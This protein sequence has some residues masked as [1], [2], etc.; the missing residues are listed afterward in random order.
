M[1]PACVSL[2][3]PAGIRREMYSMQRVALRSTCARTGGFR[4]LVLRHRSSSD[5]RRPRVSHTQCPQRV[6]A[7]ES[8]DSGSAEISVIHVVDMLTDLFILRGIPAYIRSDNGL[9]FVAAAVRQWIGGGRGPDRLH[10]ARFAVGER[11]HR[12]LQRAAARRT[13]RWRL[14]DT[15]KE[16]QVLVESRRRYYNAVR[17][18]SSLEYGPPAPEAIIPPSWSP[19]S[20]TVRRPTSSGARPSMH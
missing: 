2:S 4:G 3:S 11:L 15:L 13:P 7:R 8:R 19:G 12:E 14:V 10:R 5:R 20:A 6:N 16:A 1:R 9:E 17:P 18:R